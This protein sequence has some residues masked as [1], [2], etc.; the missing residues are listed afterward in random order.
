[1][2]K[3]SYNGPNY[4]PNCACNIKAVAISL[5]A[6]GPRSEVKSNIESA[7][8]PAPAQNSR[9]KIIAQISELE[10]SGLGTTA[11]SKQLGISAASIYYY[12]RLA[13]P[14]ASAQRNGTH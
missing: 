14:K 5:M 3:P 10:T 9:E 13:K 8:P 7:A 6:F 12:R 11:I 4:C 2:N 1:M